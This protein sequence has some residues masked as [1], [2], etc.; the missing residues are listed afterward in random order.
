LWIS[1]YQEDPLTLHFVRTS[2][3]GEIPE[4]LVPD[5]RGGF[6]V[7]V[8]LLVQGESS[9]GPFPDRF[10]TVVVRLIQEGSGFALTPNDALPGEVVGWVEA[11]RRTVWLRG[12]DLGPTKTLW[13]F[14]GR[15]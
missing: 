15:Y 7:A 3:W 11:S 8:P 5:G 10:Q 2:A 1:R 13:Q 12:R 9:D 14:R 4:K 6:T